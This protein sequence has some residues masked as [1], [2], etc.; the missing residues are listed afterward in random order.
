ML[1]AKRFVEFNT[2]TGRIRY[3]YSPIL[4][5]RLRTFDHIIPPLKSWCVEFNCNKI[6]IGRGRLNICHHTY[7][8]T[9]TMRRNP[10]SFRHCQ[11]CNLNSLGY[12]AHCH[13]ISSRDFNSAAAIN[14]FDSVYVITRT[15]PRK[16]YSN[17]YGAE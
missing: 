4:D 8:G 12:P 16:L 5:K 14:S 7:R 2:K 3:L 10:Q 11:L 17:M 13:E 6:V 9:S 1:T 15:M